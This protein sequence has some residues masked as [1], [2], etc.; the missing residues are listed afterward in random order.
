VPP[1][2]TVGGMT[3]APPLLVTRDDLLLDDLLRLAAAAGVT[4]DIADDS[5]SAMRSWSAA[6]VVLVGADEAGRV[7]EQRPPRRDGVHVVGHGPV[8]EHVFRSALTAGALDVVELP[9]SEAWVVELLTDVSDD[10]AGRPGRGRR[11]VGVIAGSGGAGA[12]TFAA[13][14]ATVSAQQ[15]PS[16]RTTG[17]PGPLPDETL[18]AWRDTDVTVVVGEDD[19]FFPLGRLAVAS[20]KRL[21]VLPSVVPGAGHLLVEEE[22]KLVADLVERAFA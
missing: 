11:T 14:V 5:T 22:P 19:R 3:S 4:L 7:A 18:D 15:E 9:A 17:A 12:T 21:G 16:T 6:A 13:A 2:T 10:A 1:G 8:D 20:R